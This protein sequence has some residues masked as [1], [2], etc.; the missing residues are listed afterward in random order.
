[1]PDLRLKDWRVHR[2]LSQ[3]DLADRSGVTKATIV[4]LEKP[5]HRLPHPRTVR[6]LAKA[7]DVQPPELYRAPDAGEESRP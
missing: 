7:L 6:R 2:A 5:G 4:A 1:M 3:S